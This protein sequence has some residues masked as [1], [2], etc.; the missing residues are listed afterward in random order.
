MGGRTIDRIYLL[1]SHDIFRHGVRSVLDAAVDVKVVGETGLA[2]EALEQI[3]RLVP[4]VVVVGIREDDQADVRRLREVRGTGTR[5]LV[6]TRTDDEDAF[7]TA[8]SAG[9][10]G[11]LTKDLSPQE[12]LSAVLSV[13]RGR[14]L[15]DPVRA[16][17]HVHGT[18]VPAEVPEDPLR[19]L[20]NQERRILDLIAEGL[21][22]RE[23][24][25]RLFLVEKT[26]RNH[27]TAVL[28][29]LGVERRTQAALIA[30]RIAHGQEP[31]ERD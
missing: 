3:P 6:L 5:M 1:E 2:D 27:V 9:A 14:N 31:R 26:V 12:L 8:M 17:R 19:A 20:T 16:L 18:R 30:A 21:S 10:N 25:D 28:A 7:A 29:K 4:D 13:A 15:I 23:I 11:Y 22:N 24:A